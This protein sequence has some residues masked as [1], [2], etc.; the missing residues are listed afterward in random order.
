MSRR[1][2]Q[3]DEADSIQLSG[4]LSHPEEFSNTVANIS[5]QS[6]RISIDQNQYSTYYEQWFVFDICDQ[7]EIGPLCASM[8]EVLDLH[9]SRNL[10]HRAVN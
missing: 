8:T 6:W 2:P 3:P 4:N 7:R 10:G 5:M 1:P 9:A